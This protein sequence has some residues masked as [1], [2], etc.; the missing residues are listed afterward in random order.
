MRLPKKNWL[1]W[2]IFAV[3]VALI[4]ATIG[5]LVYENRSLTSEPPSPQIQLGRA[6]WHESYFAVP[7]TVTNAGDH[8]AQNVQLEVDLLLPGGQKETGKVNLQY[9]PRRATRD[10]WVTF[11]HDP[12]KGKLEPRVLGYERP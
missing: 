11:Q 6:R 4:C 1:E 9:L 5:V 8:T 7:L 12:G 3:S 2:L 10:A